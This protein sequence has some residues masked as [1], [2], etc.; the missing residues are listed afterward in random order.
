MV[1]QFGKSRRGG[2]KLLP[3]QSLTLAKRKKIDLVR[4]L[5]RQH[6]AAGNTN[7]LQTLHAKVNRSC[8]RHRTGDMSSYNQPA[9]SRSLN[10]FLEHRFRDVV[11]DLDEV[12]S[13][14]GQ[15]IDSA[16]AALWRVHQDA[17]VGPNW[18]ITV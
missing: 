6:F 5:D 10:D 8:H 13:L 4:F 11:V 15:K 3:Q 2:I 16:H 12:H 18:G 1:D 17:A 9:L 7:V 14:I